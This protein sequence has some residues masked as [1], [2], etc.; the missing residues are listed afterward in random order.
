MKRL[1]LVLAVTVLGTGC[2]VVDDGPPP[3]C[4]RSVTVDWS[5]FLTADGVVLGS[6][7][8]AGVSVVDVY[9]NDVGVGSFDCSGP[10]RT[11]SLAPGANR[12]TVEGLDASGAILYRDEVSVNA[13][14]CGSQGTVVAQPAEGRVEVAY[15]F[16]PTNACFSPGPSFLWVRVRDDL[17]GAIA[18]DSAMAPE[19]YVCPATLTFRLAAGG[20]TLLSTEE[21]I[22]SSVPGRY[23]VVARDCTSRLLTVGPALTTTVPAT[24]VDAAAACP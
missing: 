20:Y 2:I 18:A 21:T 19:Q 3:P 5:G 23:E 7:A 13:S 17:T 15:S 22:R 6:C 1:A 24:L 11:I 12:V 8:A 16:Y 9:A 4:G 10:P 14:V